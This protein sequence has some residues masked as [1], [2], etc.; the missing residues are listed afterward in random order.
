MVLY[1]I[2]FNATDAAGNDA[3]VVNV[4]SVTFDTVLPTLI[5]AT[6]VDSDAHGTADR[7]TFTFSEQVNISNINNDNLSLIESAVGSPFISGTYNPGSV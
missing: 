7:L 1:I 4:T 6:T 2:T 3:T 5:S